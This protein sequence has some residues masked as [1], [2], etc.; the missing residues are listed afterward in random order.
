MAPERI[1][2]WGPP[3]RSESGGHRSGA[4]L[5]WP[6]PSNFFGSK[7]KIIRFGERFCDGQYSLVSFLF[8]VLLL[9]VPPCP[10]VCKSV[11]HVSP[12]HMES[13]PLA[14]IEQNGQNIGHI[15]CRKCVNWNALQVDHVDFGSDA[16]V[17]TNLKIVFAVFIFPLSN[18]QLTIIYAIIAC[19]TPLLFVVF[20]C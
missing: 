14:T 3:V 6:C 8:A 11:G 16:R 20:F 7:S 2:K 15:A 12:C 1:W 4:N 5:F 13:A 17:D 19:I 10:A 18:V 9:T